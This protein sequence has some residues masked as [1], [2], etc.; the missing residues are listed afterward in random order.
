MNTVIAGFP[1]LFWFKNQWHR[2]NGAGI[3]NSTPYV[4]IEPPNSELETK[5]KGNLT[6]TGNFGETYT[7]NMANQRQ[8]FLVDLSEYYNWQETQKQKTT[9]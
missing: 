2:I 5:L 1:S 9:S 6:A 4:E 3:T 8:C 7:L